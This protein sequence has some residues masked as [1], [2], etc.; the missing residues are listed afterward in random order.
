MHLGVHLHINNHGCTYYRILNSPLAPSRYSQLP[1]TGCTRQVAVACGA[2]S[3]LLAML[4]PEWISACTLDAPDE[5]EAQLTALDLAARPPAN[6][7]MVKCLLACGA[8]PT[9]RVLQT[10][11]RNCGDGSRVVSTG[12]GGWAAVRECFLGAIANSE[13]ATN[14][15]IPGLNLYVA[16]IA[17]R[18]QVPC[19]AR[20]GGMWLSTFTVGHRIAYVAAQEKRTLC[21]PSLFPFKSIAISVH[22]RPKSPHLWVKH[23][24]FIE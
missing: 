17:A 6:L 21:F 15:L 14:P 23:T 11:I 9:P 8:T 22:V 13:W 10:L 19:G 12:G 1:S 18:R 7:A 20:L 5:S 16:I 24:K 4:R 2:E 3:V